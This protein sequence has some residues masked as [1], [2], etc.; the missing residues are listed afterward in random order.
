M[1]RYD[2]LQEAMTSK[3]LDPISIRLDPEVKAALERLAKADDRSL[4]GYI[5]HLLKTHVDSVE[6]KKERSSAGR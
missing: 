6:R 3:K 4:S 5:N 2:R 1:S